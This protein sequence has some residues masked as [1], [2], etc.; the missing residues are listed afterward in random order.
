MLTATRCGHDHH[1]AVP[2]AASPAVLLLDKDL[3]QPGQ[4]AN[5]QA[6]YQE[7]IMST[8]A[9]QKATTYNPMQVDVRTAMECWAPMP[10]ARVVVCLLAEWFGMENCCDGSSYLSWYEGLSYCGASIGDY[11]LPAYEYALVHKCVQAWCAACEHEGLPVTKPEINHDCIFPWEYHQPG[12]NQNVLF[13]IITPWKTKAKRVS[14]AKHAMAKLHSMWQ[15]DVV[16]DSCDPMQLYN[17]VSLWSP[18]G[19][20]VH[21]AQDWDAQFATQDFSNTFTKASQDQFKRVTLSSLDTYL[22]NYAQMQTSLAFMEQ[23]ADHLRRHADALQKALLEQGQKKGEA[24][25]DTEWTDCAK[26]ELET[27]KSKLVQVEDR[28][29]EVRQR[30]DEMQLQQEQEVEA[31]KMEAE[32]HRLAAE[33]ALQQLRAK[34]SSGMAPDAEFMNKERELMHRLEEQQQQMQDAQ[35]LQDKLQ[36]ASD[37]LQGQLSECRR[38]AEGNLQKLVEAQSL[39]DKMEKNTQESG[40]R[41]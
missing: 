12:A 3:S 38:T 41:H 34:E 2:L 28:E 6:W 19:A 24:D 22:Q 1:L 23:Q 32:K 10:T 21:F 30:A 18:E 5:G 31:A 11:C 27:L 13:Y 8:A 20:Q 36:R 9:C 4:L 14:M 26:D 15:M 37:L 40:T 17:R 35:A 7:R 29:K 16:R 25:S 39:Q 33:A